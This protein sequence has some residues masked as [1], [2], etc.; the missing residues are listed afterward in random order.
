MGLLDFFRK[1]ETRDNYTNQSGLNLFRNTSSGVRVTEESSVGLTAVWAAVRLLSETVAAM[2]LNLYRTEKDGSK[3]LEQDHTLNKIVSVTPSPNYTSYIW[4][5]T[6][7]NHLLLWGNAFCLIHRNGGARVIEIEML[8]PSDVRVVK[9]ENDGLT[10]YE[11]KKGTYNAKEILHFYGFSFDGLVGK[12]PIQA[13]KEALGLGLA[14]QKFGE[15]FFGRGANLSGV[16]SHPG[17]LTEDAANRLRNSWSDRF[18]GIHNSHQTAIL[19]EGVEFKPIGMPLNDAQF[20][21]T[22]RFSVEEVAR[23]F[24]VPPHLIGDLTRSTY[25]NIEQQSLEFTKYSLQPYLVN[26]EQE[27]NKK[28]LTERE[29]GVN[30]LK[31]KTAELLRADANSRG[32]YYRK[33]FEVG[34]LSPNEIRKMEDMNAIDDGDK[35]FVPLNLGDINKQNDSVEE[36]GDV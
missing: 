30:Y 35:H 11:T 13:C 20:I 2:P 31:F 17:R 4:R 1:K 24:R 12:S 19:E 27:L 25:S 28:L 36:D 18:G 32:D 16:L 23:I 22:R 26:I 7:M 3:F 5:S 6:F 21:E 8:H 15:N 9:N 10:Y 33:M 29:Q 34:A 14:S